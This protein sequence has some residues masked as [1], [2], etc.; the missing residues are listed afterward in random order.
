MWVTP[1]YQH[2]DFDWPLSIDDKIEIFLDRTFG[3]QLNVANKII[4]GERDEQGT[5]TLK[6]IHHSGFAVLHIVLNYFEM[7]AKYQDGFTEHG[8]SGHYFRSGVISVFSELQNYPQNVIKSVLDAVYE[9][10]RCGLYH[11]GMTDPRI[12]LTGEINVAM[13]FDEINQRLVI[14][15]HLLVH[16]LEAHLGEY[17]NLLRDPANIQMRNNFEQRFDYDAK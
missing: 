7:I 1:N 16:V 3:W 10:A 4:N 13:A 6:P 2:T 5:I 17:G 11:G 15:P 12:M 9:G 14:N 8:K